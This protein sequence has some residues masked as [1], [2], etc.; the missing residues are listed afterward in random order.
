M[1]RKL[2]Y[3]FPLKLL[4]TI[5][6]AF[7]RPPTHYED[8]I[9]DQH[10]NYFFCEKLE[11]VQY[12]TV[13]AIIAAIQ[14]GS[15]EKISQELGLE[16]LKSRRWCKLLSSMFEIMNEKAPN[17]LINFIPKCQQFIRSRNSQIPT[18]HCQTDCFKYSLFPLYLES[19]VQPWR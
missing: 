15:R 6:N 2:R 10:Q 14:G 3:G 4:V 1:I 5:Y 18:F 7:L 13:L 8:N 9:Y 12:K 17:Y 16:T 11:S 19:L